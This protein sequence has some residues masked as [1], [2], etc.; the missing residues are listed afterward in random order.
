MR[1]PT[2]LWSTCCMHQA[3]VGHTAAMHATFCV[4]ACI[5]RQDA[6]Q[7]TW[8]QHIVRL[9]HLNY[10]YIAWLQGSAVSLNPVGNLAGSMG[11]IAKRY[12]A[13]SSPF[14]F[15]VGNGLGMHQSISGLPSLGQSHG[16]LQAGKSNSVNRLRSVPSY[17]SQVGPAF[18]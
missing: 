6:S 10:N 12:P 1:Q 7:L 18:T 16:L 13:A 9:M 8:Q 5:C 17:Q 15:G 4:R 11:A 3:D 14:S 2:R